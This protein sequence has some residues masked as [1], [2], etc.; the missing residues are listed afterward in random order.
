[1]NGESV[2]RTDDSA[3]GA[4]S[5]SVDRIRMV[6]RGRAVLSVEHLNIPQGGTY[7]LLGAS[8]AGKSTLLRLIG[9]V[10]QATA[11]TISYDGRPVHIG[12]LA[13]RRRVAAVLQK[14]YLLRG[15]IGANVAYGLR[16]RGIGSAE[17]KARVSEALERVGLAGWEARSALTLSGGEA[18]RVALARAIVLQPDLL[19]LDEPLS[20]L[21]PLLKRDLSREFAEILSSQHVTALYVTHDKDEAA[22]V[23]DRIGV[24]RD[25]SLVA[26]GD[27]RSILALPADDWLAAFLGTERALEGRV[28]DSDGENT[29]VQCDKVRLSAKES[30]PI[31][32][33]VR[34][35]VR[36]EDVLIVEPGARLVGLTGVNH[37]PAIVV[38]IAEAGVSLRVVVETGGLRFSSMVSWSSAE[39]LDL[40]PGKSVALLFKSAAVQLEA[41]AE[42]ADTRSAPK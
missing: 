22:A 27:T 30:L 40:A 9:L 18:Q 1:M 35:G 20:Y 39:S 13:A 32:T 15:T 34:V 7:A 38:A 6:Y 31:G 5:V 28:V 11:G 19:L 4:M 17:C 36:P 12:S 14:P 29:V 25:G 10:E 41:L 8:G 16:M 2:I 26:E 42:Q 21:D 3:A 33:R 37:L 24:M 23:A